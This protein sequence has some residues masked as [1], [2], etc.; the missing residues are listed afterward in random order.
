[1]SQPEQPNPEHRSNNAILCFCIGAGLAA[2]AYVLGIGAVLGAAPDCL[3]LVAANPV[4]IMTQIAQTVCQ[5]FGKGCDSAP[6]GVRWIL[7]GNQTN[8]HVAHFTAASCNQIETNLS[9][10]AI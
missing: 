2:L 7:A 9:N 6:T 8:S 10:A 5:V 1:M 3:L 4:D